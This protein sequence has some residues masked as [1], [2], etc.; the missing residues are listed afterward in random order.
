M[1]RSTGD[2]RFFNRPVKNKSG[3]FKKKKEEEDG[4]R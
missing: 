2:R 3:I 1:W 4:I